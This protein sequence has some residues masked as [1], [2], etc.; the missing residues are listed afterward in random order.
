VEVGRA[1][2]GERAKI[3]TSCLVHFNLDRAT[4]GKSMR[5][6]QR[7]KEVANEEHVWWK[8]HVSDPIQLT[9]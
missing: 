5:Q 6:I 1:E 8:K 2:K 3:F 9:E 4:H 7:G